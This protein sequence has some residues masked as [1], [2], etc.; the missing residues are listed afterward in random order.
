MRVG[1]DERLAENGADNQSRLVAAPLGIEKG[2]DEERREKGRRREDANV[3]RFCL[4]RPKHRDE[5]VALGPMSQVVGHL[6]PAPE[7]AAHTLLVEPPSC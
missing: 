6:G 5:D 4:Q 1:P 2:R 3:P 7:A